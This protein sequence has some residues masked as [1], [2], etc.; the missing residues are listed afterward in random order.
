MSE[1]NLKRILVT[2][3]GRNYPVKVDPRE[4]SLIKTIEKEINDKINELQL[5]YQGKD[6]QDYMSLAILSFAFELQQAKKS[7]DSLVLEKRLDE[8]EALLNP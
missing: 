7:E 5:S 1:D 2:I 6:V 8:I 3:A 4:E